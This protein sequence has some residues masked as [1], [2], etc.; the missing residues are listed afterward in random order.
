MSRSVVYKKSVFSHCRIKMYMNLR[1]TNVLSPL[2]KPQ[3][4]VVHDHIIM[5][6]H[7]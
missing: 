5:H 2:V 4:L 1:R 6:V 3:V 7:S